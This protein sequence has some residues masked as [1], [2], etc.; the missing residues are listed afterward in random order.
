L[1]TPLKVALGAAVN[2][3]PNLLVEADAVWRDW[4]STDALSDVFEDQWTI[5][6][7]AQYTMGALKLRAGYQYAEDLMRGNPGG[8]LGGLAGLGTL[9]LNTAITL[10]VL[11]NV[12]AAN[13]IVKLVQATLLPVAWKHTWTAGL[14]YAF[15]PNVSL[16][17]HAAVAMKDDI[18]RTGGATGAAGGELIG[19]HKAELKGY[20]VGAGLNFKF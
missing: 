7:G 3:T 16:D 19:T 8:T 13:D 18:T 6:L 17:L 5:S 9:P 15:S 20:A 4:S 2:V 12:L 10:P 1:E 14:G 11:S